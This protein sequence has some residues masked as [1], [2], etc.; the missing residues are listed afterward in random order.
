[1]NIQSFIR[2][3]VCIN[4]SHRA[5]FLLLNEGNLLTNLK[6]S[7]Q[8]VSSLC[9]LSNLLLE[10]AISKVVPSLCVKPEKASKPISHRAFYLVQL[11]WRISNTVTF[12]L[13]KLLSLYP[14]LVL[15]YRDELC[16]AGSSPLAPHWLAWAAAIT[17]MKTWLV[18]SST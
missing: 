1:M 8:V 14:F 10:S 16:H 3:V 18:I 13:N 11:F 17:V 15:Y 5:F 2:K 7:S 4:S 9:V 6:N 12:S